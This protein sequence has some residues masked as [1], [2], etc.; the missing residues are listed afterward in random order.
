[1]E[2]GTRLIVPMLLTDPVWELLDPL[3]RE[4]R[5][6]NTFLSLLRKTGTLPPQGKQTE[7]REEGDRWTHT[8]TSTDAGAGLAGREFLRRALR[9]SPR[10]PQAPTSENSVRDAAQSAAPCS[11][12]TPT[13]S[14]IR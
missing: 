4:R 13:E 2:K 1:M 10:F 7:R 12:P 3:F 9:A 11:S 8:Q 6:R 5:E 14:S